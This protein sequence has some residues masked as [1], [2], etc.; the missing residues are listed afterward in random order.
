MKIIL[1]VLL[2]VFCFL[3]SLSYFSLGV[4]E[5]YE[6]Q[7]EGFHLNQEELRIAAEKKND[8]ERE[9]KIVLIL[10]FTSLIGICGVS[11]IKT[12]REE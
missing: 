7:V 11:L 12:K 2:L 3:M 9:K 10:G 4:S 5:K 6:T 1:I 8:I